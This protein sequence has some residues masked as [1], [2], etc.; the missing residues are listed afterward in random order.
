[1]RAGPGE[2]DPLRLIRARPRGARHSTAVMTKF[3]GPSRHSTVV[4]WPGA[5]KSAIS[6]VRRSPR[7]NSPSSVVTVTVLWANSSPSA[8]ARTVCVPS[9]SRF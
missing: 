6:C 9:P 2:S 7:A 1:M 8:R 3:C 5:G 4:V